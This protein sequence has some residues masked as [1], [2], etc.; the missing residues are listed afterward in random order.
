VRNLPFNQQAFSIGRRAAPACAALL[1]AIA[2][3]SS[4]GHH[5]NEDGDAGAAPTSAGASSGT[6]AGGGGGSQSG[7][8]SSG[9]SEDASGGQGSTAADGCAEYAIASC[10]RAQTCLP[11]KFA[12]RYSSLDDCAEV[13]KAQ[14]AEELVAPGT[15]QTAK[16]LAECTSQLQGQDCAGWFTSSAL[17]CAP[18]GELPNGDSCRFGSQCVTGFCAVSAGAWC[19]TCQPRPVAGAACRPEIRQCEA[20][21]LCAYKCPNGSTCAA[22][23]RDWLCAEPIAAG[24]ACEFSIECQGDLMCSDG[25]CAPGEAAGA[26]CSNDTGGAQCDFL[27]TLVCVGEPGA[28]KCQKSNYGALGAACDISQAKLC[29]AN[30]SCVDSAGNYISDGPGT[31]GPPAKAGETC[32]ASHRCAPPSECQAE[33]CT[34]PPAACP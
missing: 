13:T 33:V 12:L 6:G 23:E 4:N 7:G 30:G 34:P 2:C 9:G 27:A 8:S 32:N 22:E 26:V 16:A 3:G 15:G 24:Q 10:E 31:C 21:L 17:K 28:T 14:C 18:R 29:A 20:G 11:D 5:G 19:G 25:K 1:L